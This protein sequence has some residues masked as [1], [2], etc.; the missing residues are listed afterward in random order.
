MIS[1]AIAVVPVP[2]SRVAVASISLSTMAANG[3]AAGDA[4]KAS[5]KDLPRSHASI[6]FGS[7]G[8][9]PRYGTPNCAAMDAGVARLLVADDDDDDDEDDDDDDDDEGVKRGA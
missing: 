2:A 4:G 7:I 1:I 8:S 3:P 6:M 5:R 9:L